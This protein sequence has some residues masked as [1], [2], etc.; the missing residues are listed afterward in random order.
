[1]VKV[2]VP[3]F[4][5]RVPG[6]GDISERV[7]VILAKVHLNKVPDRHGQGQSFTT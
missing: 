2:Q 5:D 4:R 1:M 6:S 3:Q 7:L